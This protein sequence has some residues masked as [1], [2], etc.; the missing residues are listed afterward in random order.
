ME[1]NF[2]LEKLK[3]Q[4]LDV[5]A[6]A[7]NVVRSSTYSENKIDVQKLLLTF[8]ARTDDI[9]LFQA[10]QILTTTEINYPITESENL[11]VAWALEKILGYVGNQEIAVDSDWLMNPKS[12]SGGL[13]LW[14]LKIQSYNLKI[15]YIPGMSK[16]VS[17]MLSHPIWDTEFN[18]RENCN[19]VSVDMT[20]RNSSSIRETH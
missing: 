16:I 11:V 5:E 3:L 18:N 8:R 13:A 15:D 12:H 10:S 2:E 20:I 7:D 9:T 4:F 19:F 1:K 17:G 6:A 14:A